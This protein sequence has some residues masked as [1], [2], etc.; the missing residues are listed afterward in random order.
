MGRVGQVLV[1]CVCL[2]ACADGGAGA[3]VAVDLRT[4]IVPAFEFAGV[5]T[6]LL[7]SGGAVDSVERVAREGESYVEGIRVAELERVP[8]GGRSLLVE[9]IDRTGETVAAR[10]VRAEVAGTTT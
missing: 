1:A 4:D 9:L 3:R 2:S 6:S 5:R 10:E 7:A 8:E